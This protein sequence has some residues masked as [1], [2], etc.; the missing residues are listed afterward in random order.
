MTTDDSLRATPADSTAAAVTATTPSKSL[1]RW[2]TMFISLMAL[3]TCGYLLFNL[4]ND[5]PETPLVATEQQPPAIN[6][7]SLIGNANKAPSTVAT[8]APAINQ[9][10]LPDL[11]TSDAEIKNAARQLNS[12]LAWVKWITTEQAIRKFVIIIDNLTTGKITQK[13]LPIPKPTA[14]FPKTKNDP[15]TTSDIQGYLDNRSFERYTPYVNTFGQI[16]NTMTAALYQR[17]SPLMEQ[18]F[19]ELGYSDRNFHDTLMQAFDVLLSAPIVE[20]NIALI[21]PSVLYQFADPNLEKALPVHKQL[22]R[23]GPE[24]TRRLQAK[25]RQLQTL[26]KTKAS[27]P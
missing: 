20:S 21:R 24:N 7:P 19:A 23:M 5:S 26:L 13:Y 16:N 14:P 12:A 8:T 9:P 27:N 25:I 22:L 3:L 11:N 10:A 17:Y 2:L 1:L 6:E 4:Y 15:K 18:A